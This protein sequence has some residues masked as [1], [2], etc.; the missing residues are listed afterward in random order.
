M[1]TRRRRRGVGVVPPSLLALALLASAA[2][3]RATGDVG[4][5]GSGHDRDAHRRARALAQT[6]PSGSAYDATL[7]ACAVTCDGGYVRDDTANTTIDTTTVFGRCDPCAPGSAR[8]AGSANACV[9]CPVGTSNSRGGQPACVPCSYQG[10]TKY[11]NASGAVTCLECPAGTMQRAGDETDAQGAGELLSGVSLDEC[12]C[13]PGAYDPVANRTGAPCE[14]C[15]KGA[16]CAGDTRRPTSK[17]LYYGCPPPHDD[18]FLRCHRMIDNRSPCLGE[19]RCMEGFEKQSCSRCASGFYR[20]QR[21]CVRCPSDGAGSLVAAYAFLLVAFYVVKK[22]STI[23]LPSMYIILTYV[24]CLSIVGNRQGWGTERTKTFLKS[25]EIVNFPLDLFIPSC[26]AEMPFVHKAAFFTV[27]PIFYVLVDVVLVENFVKHAWPRLADALAACLVGLIRVKYVFGAEE[28]GMRAEDEAAGAR[29]RLRHELRGL[30][31][32]RTGRFLGGVVQAWYLASP[33]EAEEAID[34]TFGSGNALAKRTMRWAGKRASMRAK[35]RKGVTDDADVTATADVTAPV[36]A[37]LTFAQKCTKHFFEDMRLM[38]VATTSALLKTLRCTPVG[39]RDLSKFWM[40]SAWFGASPTSVLSADPAQTCW[41]GEH[42]KLVPYFVVM[43]VLY[44]V[45]YPIATLLVLND[46]KNPERRK[47]WHP[48]VYGRLYRRFEPQY[49]WWEVVYLVRRLCLVSFRTLMNDR[50][51]EVYAAGTMQGWQ[52]LCFV[53]TLCAAL[54]A[55]FY[56]HP[57]KLEHM[58]LLDATLLCCLFLVVW[59]SMAFEV[60]LEDTPEMP[61]LEF[62]VF[63]VVAVSVLVSAYALILDAYHS[64]LKSGRQPPRWI[65][66]VVFACTPPPVLK[67]LGLAS[68]STAA[69]IERLAGEIDREKGRGGAA[70]AAAAGAEAAT[71]DAGEDADASVVRRRAP[72]ASTRRVMEMER[73]MERLKRR[74]EDVDTEGDATPRNS[75]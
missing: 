71:G 75:A 24:Q 8:E 60:A 43:L 15:P 11:A 17:P 61:V 62:L 27:T 44:G 56:A 58:D 51:A 55:Q 23:V 6:C 45:G 36:D 52:A 10:V 68:K 5:F 49:Y 29:G 18:F 12:A 57:F 70:A 22:L 73:K 53:V 28:E 67:G 42:A 3:A 14:A 66:W 63:A 41:E 38:Y 4:A 21:N 35:R 64:H 26:A 47:G 50:R 40:G 48:K 72:P 2:T 33:V 74:A 30:E 20:F 37:P 19:N 54:L 65:S 34:A 59:L 25:A 13:E 7:V 69:Q 32:G 46:C 31:S 39:D 9:A 1:E 16:D